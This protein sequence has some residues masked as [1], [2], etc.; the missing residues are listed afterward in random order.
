MIPLPGY[1]GKYYVVRIH[2][3]GDAPLKNLRLHWSAKTKVLVFVPPPKGGDLTI[4][5]GG[6]APKR[7][8]D[9][10]KYADTLGPPHIIGTPGRERESREYSPGWG[11]EVYRYLLW[12][13]L[14]VVALGLF[15]TIVRYLARS[16]DAA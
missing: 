2:N 7:A 11:P 9:I 14:A 16:P 8:Y 4:Y 1:R 5:Y 12:I 13:V 15:V 6:N 10:E 3:G